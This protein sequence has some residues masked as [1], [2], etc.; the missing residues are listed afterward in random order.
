MLFSLRLVSLIEAVSYLLLIGVAMPLK[1]LA[2]LPLM[3]QIMGMAHGAL[4]VLLIVLLV[5]AGF[6]T[7]W[8]KSRLLTLALASLVPVVPFLLDRRVRT[9]IEQSQQS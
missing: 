2:G 3:V 7:A 9:W 5:L 1:Y 4:F 8:P 6:V